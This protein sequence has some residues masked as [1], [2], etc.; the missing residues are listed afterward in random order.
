MSRKKPPMKQGSP[1][2]IAQDS[3]VNDPNVNPALK[4]DLSSSPGL[5]DP[6]P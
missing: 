4:L 2:F 5:L 6:K 1:V 3:H